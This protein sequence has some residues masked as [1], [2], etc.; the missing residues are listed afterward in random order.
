MEMMA[1]VTIRGAKYFIGNIDGK[2]LNS[3]SIYVDVELRGET[4]SGV[5]TNEVRVENSDIVKGILH[6]PMPFIAE[7]SMMETTNGKAGGDRKVVTS[8]KPIM[9]EAKTDK[10]PS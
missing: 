10:V 4:S 9:R 8:I 5:C 3:A 1:R 6:N 2:E 7:V